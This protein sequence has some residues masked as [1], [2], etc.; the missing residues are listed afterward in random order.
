LF[1][2][3]SRS[4]QREEE[5]EERGRLLADWLASSSLPLCGLLAL[6]CKEGRKGRSRCGFCELGSEV[7]GDGVRKTEMFCGVV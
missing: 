5:E 3:F 1:V 2:A 7:S 6:G 4:G